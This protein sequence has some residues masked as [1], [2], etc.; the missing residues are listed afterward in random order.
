MPAAGEI[1]PPET[2]RLI[3]DCCVAARPP[4]LLGNLKNKRSYSALSR[5]CRF[6]ARSC[7]FF[8]FENITL[9]LE[10]D[11]REFRALLEATPPT[12]LQ[13]I[14]SLTKNVIANVKELNIPW[15]HTIPSVILSMLPQYHDNVRF[16]YRIVWQPTASAQLSTPLHPSLPRSLPSLYTPV[17][18][19]L[20]YNAS[21]ANAEQLGKL[22]RGLIHL[23]RLL[24][25][26]ITWK[27][28]PDQ[29][30]FVHTRFGGEL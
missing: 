23:R 28:A 3:V 4:L 19:V 15:L 21:F 22:L 30:S 17:T 7:R 10:N 5:V 1:I 29:Q 20:L 25:A 8:V 24:L 27:Q 26:Y 14:C 12:G 6:W 16:E 18:S 9:S 13:L 11:V 2:I